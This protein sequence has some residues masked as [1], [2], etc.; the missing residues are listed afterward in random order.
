MN[1]AEYFSGVNYKERS[2]LCGAFSPDPNDQ[3][4]VI[5]YAPPG[6]DGRNAYVDVVRAANQ[7]RESGPYMAEGEELG[8]NSDTPVQSTEETSTVSAA[9]GVDPFLVEEIN[10]FLTDLENIKLN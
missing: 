3:Y 7:M 6:V 9:S 5:G 10:G 1:T 2:F 4:V 8:K